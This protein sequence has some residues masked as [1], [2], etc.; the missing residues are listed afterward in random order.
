M[1]KGDEI[2]EIYIIPPVIFIPKR[3]P[4]RLGN[5]WII[6][7]PMDMNELWALIKRKGKIIEGYLFVK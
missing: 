4:V 1:M 6:Y 7:L 2:E 3:E 5:R